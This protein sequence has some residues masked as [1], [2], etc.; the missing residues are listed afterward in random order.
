MPPPLVPGMFARITDFAG[1]PTRIN[2]ISNFPGLPINPM[3]QILPPTMNVALASDWAPEGPVNRGAQF[4]NQA[5]YAARW[6]A[7]QPIQLA[8]LGRT[9]FIHC[10]QTTASEA[11]QDAFA[12]CALFALRNAINADVVRRE[13][14]R[15]SSSLTASLR[16]F[17]D[18]SSM[19]LRRERDDLIEEALPM[20]QAL[21]IY[22]CIRLF[23]DN[24]LGERA[25]PEQ[26]EDL[27]RALVTTVSPSVKTTSGTQD[28]W[29]EWIQ[30]E[31]LRRTIAITEF[32]I[33]VHAFLRQGWDQAESRLSRLAFTAQ[34]SLWDAPSSARW[35]ALRGFGPA[36][37]I[38]LS[39]WQESLAKA[40]PEDLDE[41]AILVRATFL[42]LESL[43]GWL[44][45][46]ALNW[47]QQRL[48]VV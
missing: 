7:N 8:Q 14:S 21:L 24:H 1:Q 11:L 37:E 31:S 28:C 12:A 6:L 45:F 27:L 35:K 2:T 17:F 16:A 22:Q 13:I 23:G 29:V 38:H 47:K 25:V 3:E 18:P 20:L 43:E 34:A 42:G 4:Q 5:E 26:Q 39:H 46:S 30:E 40:R 10:T 41:L 32:M 48:G 9:T 33:G 44:G 36:F 15:R 19:C